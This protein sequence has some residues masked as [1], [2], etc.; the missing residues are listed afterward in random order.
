MA[1]EWLHHLID[2]KWAEIDRLTRQVE[3]AQGS[4]FTLLKA[5]EEG[6]P[7]RELQLRVRDLER[8]LNPRPEAVSPNRP[9][10]GTDK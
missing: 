4:C 10:E 5:I 8:I 3:D 7:K 2:E 9:E 6:D 1:V